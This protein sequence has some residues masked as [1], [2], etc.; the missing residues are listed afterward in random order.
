VRLTLGDTYYESREGDI[1][2]VVEVGATEKLIFSCK[3]LDMTNKVID[4]IITEVL[5]TYVNPIEITSL[6]QPIEITPVQIVASETTKY[7]VCYAYTVTESG[8]LTLT[9]DSTAVIMLGNV[10]VV[11][12]TATLTVE[13]STED[14]TL[15]VIKILVTATSADAFNATLSFTNA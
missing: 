3:D 14:P 15:N 10:E 8:T 9:T 11:D 13:Y 7:E 6:A 12:G 2:L 5:G 1:N 4:I